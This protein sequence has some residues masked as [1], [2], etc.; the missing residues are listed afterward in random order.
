M[1]RHRLTLEKERSREADRLRI[2]RGEDTRDELQARN[3]IIPMEQA[4]DPDWRAK[5]LA[6]A[7]ANM[8]R[9]R[10]KLKVPASLLRIRHPMPPSDPA[11]V[12]DSKPH[13]T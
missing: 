4:A 5:V 9:V 1:K 10:P 12:R 13:E 6:A 2:E 3:S 7:V 8:N 11:R